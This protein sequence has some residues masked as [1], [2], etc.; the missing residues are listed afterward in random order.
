MIF[1]HVHREKAMILLVSVKPIKGEIVPLERKEIE[2]HPADLED[3]VKIYESFGWELIEKP[4]EINEENISYE[5][6]KN[7]IY[8]VKETIQYYRLRLRR[9]QNIKDCQ[10]LIELEEA[11]R[12]S[13]RELE[14]REVP[15]R[16]GLKC[17]IIAGCG[18]LLAGIP[19]LIIVIWCLS[20][21]P[22][23]L[24]S[25]QDNNEILIKQKEDIIR[26]AKRLVTKN[27]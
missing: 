19:T 6:R 3:E 15:Q 16:F 26:T 22:K 2:I 9:N 18:I 10:R 4:Q 20:R 13:E 14:E 24:Q 21:Y 27:N 17:M 1:C 25:W 11:Y 8:Q 23:Q 12:E 7:N 5:K